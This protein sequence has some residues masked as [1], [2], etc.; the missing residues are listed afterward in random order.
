MSNVKKRKTNKNYES[1]DAIFNDLALLLNPP[2]NLSVSEAAAKYR[3]LSNPGSY[4]GPWFNATAPYMVEPMNTF[5]SRDYEGMVFA[6]PAQSAKTDSLVLNTLAYSIK[7]D[8]MDM[9]LYCPGMIEARDFGIRRVD[10]LHMHSPAIGEMLLPQA[11]A[12]N[13][14]DKQYSTGMLFTIS[15]PTR[16]TLAGK[17]IGRVVL[18]DRDRMDDN[19]EGDGEPFDLAM[20]RTTTFGSYAMTVAES[21]PSRP[22]TNPKW[23]PQSLHQAPPCEGILKLY[24]RGDRRR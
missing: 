7:V 24:N 20:K 3:Y 14:F 4:I 23:I 6:G 13:R 8:P 22:I 5:T 15:W 1:I 12:D 2:E 16:A 19:I 11:D 17:P 18:T 21:S 10:R 9:I